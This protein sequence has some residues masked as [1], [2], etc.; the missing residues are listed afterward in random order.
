MDID[1]VP[2]PPKLAPVGDGLHREGL[3][4]LDQVVAPDPG[5]RLAQQ[6]ADRL[7]RREEDLPGI[8]AASGVGRDPGHGREAVGFREGE[9]GHH[10][11]AGA[12]VEP[13]RIPGGHGSAVL[14]EDRLQL[15]EGLGAGVLPR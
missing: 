7:H 2:V 12:V 9:R 13:R 4:G 3:V 6:I 10:Q 5:A 8:A 11:G 1:P 15:G 14:A